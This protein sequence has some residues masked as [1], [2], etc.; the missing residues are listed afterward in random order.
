MEFG[1]TSNC[2]TAMTTLD[3]VLAN[4]LNTYVL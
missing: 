4:P 3:F 1:N 2:I